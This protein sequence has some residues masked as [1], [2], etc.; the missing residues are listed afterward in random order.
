MAL[1]LQRHADASLHAAVPV[2]TGTH[3]MVAYGNG[4]A[5]DFNQMADVPAVVRKR[6]VTVEAL[7]KPRFP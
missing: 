2:A 5:V 4:A 6:N 7:A 1:P 3:D